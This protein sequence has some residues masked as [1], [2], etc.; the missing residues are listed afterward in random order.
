MQKFINYLPQGLL[1]SFIIKML[2]ISTSFSDMG[3]VFALSA[4][5][6]IQVYLEKRD[7]IQEIKTVVNKQNDVIQTMAVEL[8][9]IK[10]QMEGIKLKNEFTGVGGINKRVG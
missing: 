10:T 3:I 1:L 2:I 8:S 9:K 5:C 7:E 6:G 4:I